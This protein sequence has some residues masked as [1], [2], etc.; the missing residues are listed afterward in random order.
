[1]SKH[2]MGKTKCSLAAV[3]GNL[4]LEQL[5]LIRPVL[6]IITVCDL[7]SSLVE[8]PRNGPGCWP[9]LQTLIENISKIQTGKLGQIQKQ[10]TMS[11]NVEM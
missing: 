7:L 9:N 11:V 10:D 4:T 8:R 2:Q 3:E 5:L 6:V 1:M